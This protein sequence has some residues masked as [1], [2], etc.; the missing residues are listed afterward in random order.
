M[1]A[2]ILHL[3]V[4]KIQSSEG[5]AFG[6]AIL[7]MVGAGQFPNVETACAKLI[8]VSETYEPDT[9][10][11]TAYDTRYPIYA[12]LYAALKDSFNQIAR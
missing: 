6:A 4:E 9:A 5:P 8:E 1:I 12:G 11:A 10:T 7:A 3:R 2:D